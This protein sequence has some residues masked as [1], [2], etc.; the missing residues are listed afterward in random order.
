MTRLSTVA[1]SCALV[2]LALPSIGQADHSAR[3]TKGTILL[4][5]GSSIFA[6]IDIAGPGGFRFAGFSDSAASDAFCLPCCPG[7]ALR[8]AAL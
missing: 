5:E 6:T 1:L 7:S 8:Y 3:I 4:G 2:G